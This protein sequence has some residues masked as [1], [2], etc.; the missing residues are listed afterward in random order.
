MIKESS[1]FTSLWMKNSLKGGVELSK[2]TKI[3]IQK[4]N[5]NRVNLFIDEA[6]FMGCYVD[7]VYRFNLEQGMEI[8]TDKLKKLIEEQE[9]EA[10]KQKALDLITRAEKSE[11]AMRN[12]LLERY[13]QVAVDRVIDFLKNYSI[14]D[15]ERYARNIVQNNQLYKRNGRNKIKQTLYLK[16]IERTEI[17]KSIEYIDEDKELENAIYLA[18]KKIRKIKEKDERIIKNKLYQH[19][20]YKG[21]GYNIIKKAISSVINSYE[22]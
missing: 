8:D 13:S 17:E 5:K 2:I 4:N 6:F 10:C 12:K 18:E 22:D 3:E 9:Y 15:D 20:S 21:F 7:L 14:L 11:K 16:G 1:L 19:L